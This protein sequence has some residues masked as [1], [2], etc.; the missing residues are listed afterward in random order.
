MRNRKDEGRNITVDSKYA[1]E[2]IDYNADQKSFKDQ[3]STP[4]IPFPDIAKATSVQ[5]AKLTD[6]QQS[7]EQLDK[8]VTRTLGAAYPPDRIQVRR[9]IEDA[10]M[11]AVLAIMKAT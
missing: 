6:L 4:T 7:F 9:H 10:Y 2:P 3:G 11:A 5:K 1:K 8:M